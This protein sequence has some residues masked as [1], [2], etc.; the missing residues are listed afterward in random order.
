MKKLPDK[1]ETIPF[2]IQG[3]TL[4]MMDLKILH[5]TVQSS[6]VQKLRHA[7]LAG[8]FSPGQRLVEA[9]LC[10]LLGIS[11][12][13]VREALRSLEAERLIEIVPNRGPIVRVL[14]W[15]EAKQIYEA[16]AL[17]E[18]EAAALFAANG[19]SEQI[20]ELRTALRR[21]KDAV[22]HDDADGRVAEAG[23]FYE[24]IMSAAGNQILYELAQ[25]LVARIAFLRR[26]SM[27]RTGR[28]RESAVE[29][30]RI[31]TAIEK[32]Q[33]EDA[34]QAAVQHVMNACAAAEITFADVPATA[35]PRR[36]GQKAA[37]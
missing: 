6:A 4:P 21:F 14:S 1:I 22:K 27:S 29:M 28:A 37:K 25:G 26:R 31:A 16:R 10:E 20:A 32:H 9:N 30:T 34:R 3:H 13:S 2:V 17:L 33:R 19:T 36:A 15:A 23:R 8:V 5:T 11:R 12:T 18:G 35:E 7:I 24:I